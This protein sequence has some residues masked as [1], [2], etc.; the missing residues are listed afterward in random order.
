[1]KEIVIIGAGGVGKEVLW[2]IEQI[3]NIKST[4]RV[5]GFIDDDKLKKDKEFLGY[6]ILGNLEYLKEIK[7]E[8]GVVVAI[9]NYKVRKS[10]VEKLKG[11]K[12]NF[13]IIKH[14]NVK[15]HESVEIGEGTIIYEGV[16]ISPNVKIGKQVIISPKCGIGHDSVIED[17]VGLLWNV[18]ISGNDFIEEGVLFGSGSTIIQGK[19]V[20]KESIIGAGAVVTKDINET[21]IYK[22]IPAKEKNK[23]EEDKNGEKNTR[24]RRNFTSN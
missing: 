7:Y 6:K 16:I 8:G 19:K 14:P 5:L 4:Y 22:G 9:A 23:F 1:M 24:D 2:I 17:Y 15:L 10:I 18:N 12:V 21:G 11:L 13:P 3:N 20:K